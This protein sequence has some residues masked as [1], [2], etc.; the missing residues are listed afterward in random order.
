MPEETPKTD[1]NYELSNQGAL[2]AV[3]YI[4]L[5]LSL[6][7]YC[8]VILDNGPIKSRQRPKVSK[9]NFNPANYTTA[10][11]EQLRKKH[12]KPG[13]PSPIILSNIRRPAAG[14]IFATLVPKLRR[15][16]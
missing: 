3:L 15:K 7:V 14:S 9:S 4:L 5:M 2:E 8:T 10:N 1:E 6:P 13:I 12:L 11:I 16:I